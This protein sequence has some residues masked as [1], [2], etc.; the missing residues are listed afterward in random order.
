MQSTEHEI[1]KNA[2][3]WTP[4]RCKIQSTERGIDEMQSTE[5]EIDENVSYWTRNWWKCKLLNTELM[6][7]QSTCNILVILWRGKESSNTKGMNNKISHA[8]GL[9]TSAS[10]RK[11]KSDIIIRTLQIPDS[12][13]NCYRIPPINFSNQNVPDWYAT[14]ATEHE[15][16]LLNRKSTKMQSTEHVRNLLNTN[17]MKMQST[18]HE[19]DKNANLLKTKSMKTVIYGKHTKSAKHELDESSIY[20]TQNWRKC[21][22]LNTKSMKMQST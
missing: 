3:Y 14:L 21:N 9:S 6:K 13:F 17:S 12:T 20:W 15:R 18:D 11:H 2:S 4:N 5:H 10:T 19:I 16:L 7:L 1:D 22:L 8:Q